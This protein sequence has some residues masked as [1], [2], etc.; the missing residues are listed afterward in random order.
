ML[1]I[2]SDDKGRNRTTVCSAIGYRQVIE[3]SYHG[4]LRIVEPYC[5]GIAGPSE[6]IAFNEILVCYQIGGYDGYGA[7]FGWKLYRFSEV[8]DIAVADRNISGTR[9]GYDLDKLNMK[10]I[11]C[12]ASLDSGCNDETREESNRTK[13]SVELQIS[14]NRRET[15]GDTSW[16][17]HLKRM[18]RFQWS[19]HVTSKLPHRST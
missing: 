10:L 1:K 6:K 12:C 5:L 13:P 9:P 2:S 14:S 18:K 7:N 4:G 11:H 15:A 3:F 17:A 16:V 19:H 8:S